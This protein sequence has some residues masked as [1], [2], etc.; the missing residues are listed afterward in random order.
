MLCEKCKKRTATVFYNENLNGKTRSY[1]LCGE[2]AARLREKGDLQDITSMIGSFADPFSELHDDLFGGFFGMPILKSSP[3]EKKC[4]TCGCTYADISREG[5]VGCAD[6]YTVFSKELERTLQSVHGTTVHTGT[7][8]S[9]HRA[10]QARA[11]QLKKLKMAMQEAI[12]K[13]DFERAAT[14]RDDIRK[15]EAESDGKEEA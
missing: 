12:E 4:S 1:S 10:K 13:E 14:L 2:C 7:V 3:A 11:E 15:L 8:P 9:R 6:C 5:R